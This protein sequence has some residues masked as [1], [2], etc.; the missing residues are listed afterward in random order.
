MSQ[1]EQ[2]LNHFTTKETLKPTTFLGQN[3]WVKN[4]PALKAPGSNANSVF[5]QSN[6][7]GFIEI[8]TLATMCG[9]KGKLCPWKKYSIDL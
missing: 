7:L 2:N 1:Q 6:I 9:Q 4:N 8:L 3:Q 5:T